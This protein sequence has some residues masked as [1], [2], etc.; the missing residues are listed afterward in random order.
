[1]YKR[2]GRLPDGLRLEHLDDYYRQCEPE[3]VEKMCTYT[4]NLALGNLKKLGRTDIT[5]AHLRNP[6]FWELQ[7]KVTAAYDKTDQQ[8][9]ADIDAKTDAKMALCY[10]PPNSTW[11]QCPDK[12]YPASDP[13]GVPETVAAYEAAGVAVKDAKEAAAAF[14]REVKSRLERFSQGRR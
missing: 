6:A 13:R 11:S 5:E 2:E 9:K 12:S 1:M 3:G 4:V 8:F 10:K 7:E 14:H